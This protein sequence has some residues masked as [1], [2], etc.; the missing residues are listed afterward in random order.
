MVKESDLLRKFSIIYVPRKMYFTLVCFVAFVTR[1][2]W[3]RMV[4]SNPSTA[5]S[6]FQTE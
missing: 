6:K 2:M 1:A 5:E 3:A 4:T